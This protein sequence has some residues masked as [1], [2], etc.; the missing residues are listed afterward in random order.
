MI[1]SHRKAGALVAGTLAFTLVVAYGCGTTSRQ[2]AGQGAGQGAAAGA[3]GGLLSAVIFGGDPV[4]AA[5][6]GAVWGAST[7]A[8]VGAMQGSQVDKQRSAQ[9]EQQQIAQ[10]RAEI[11]NDA[12]AGLEALVDCKHDVALGYSREA[13]KARNRDHALAGLWLEALSYAD[14]GDRQQANAVLPRIAKAAPN[15]SDAKQAA[16]VLQETEGSLRDIRAHYGLAR[17]CRGA[18]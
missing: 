3:V 5:A 13:T 18:R 14:R 7:G 6:R 17:Q 15:I 4:G 10:L 16:T 8:V 11:G 1:P 9:Q 12:Y 2:M